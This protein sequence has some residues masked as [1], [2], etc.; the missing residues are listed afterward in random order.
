MRMLLHAY[1][2]DLMASCHSFFW[3]GGIRAAE[4]IRSNCRSRQCVQKTP[5]PPK[6]INLSLANL[7]LHSAFLWKKTAVFPISS[8]KMA[9]ILQVLE[10]I[11]A[12]NT[13][14]LQP[15]W[16]PAKTCLQDVIAL[17]FKAGRLWHGIS[18]GSRKPQKNFY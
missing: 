9:P 10:Q 6:N 7:T 12:P 15:G 13:K 3:S 17:F 2:N 16:L 8:L 5:H 14:I 1:A 11:N 4:S 18:L